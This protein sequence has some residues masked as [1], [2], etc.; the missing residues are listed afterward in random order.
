[1]STI[2]DSA[3]LVE[4]FETIDSSYS[5]VAESVTLELPDS[6]NEEK[7]VYTALTSEEIAE[8]AAKYFEADYIDKQFDI[9]TDA[10]EDIAKLQAKID[11]VEQ[12]VISKISDITAE[13]IAKCLSTQQST[14]DNG[15]STSSIYADSAVAITADYD[16]LAEVAEAD[17]KT[18]IAGYNDDIE[19]VV[20]YQ[21]DALENLEAVR[22]AEIIAKTLDIEEDERDL[23][24]DIIE[25]NN[26]VERREQEYQADCALEYYD[27][28]NDE[29]DRAVTIA[30]LQLKLGDAGLADFIAQ[31]KFALAKKTVADMDFETAK[32]YLT[33]A[34]SNHLGDYYDSFVDYVYNLDS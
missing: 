8:M 27:A 19:V 11:A 32:Y 22:D 1:M 21:Q 28:A 33:I 9:N 2:Y 25:F 31:Q 6:L 24:F 20:Q 4:A 7:L 23:E 29:R 13:C 30:E 26:N 34:V 3:S 12:T 5:V 15:L 14:V 10:E 18:E 17:G 16:A